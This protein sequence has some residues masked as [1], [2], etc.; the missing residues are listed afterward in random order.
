[1][2]GSR[3]GN[4]SAEK[5]DRLGGSRTGHVTEP[6][7]LLF[8]RVAQEVDTA[9]DSMEKSRPGEKDADGRADP[10]L[11][12]L[13]AAWD[14]EQQLKQDHSGEALVKGVSRARAPAVASSKRSSVHLLQRQ[15]S[16]N[17]IYRAKTFSDVASEHPEDG[18]LRQN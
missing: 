5:E 17:S 4:R 13:N 18:G 16:G 6:Q 10:G 15:S 8:E 14:K 11:K 12:A 3:D 2:A 1:M 9:Q 7:I